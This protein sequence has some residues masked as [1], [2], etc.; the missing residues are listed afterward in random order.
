[1]VLLI[2]SIVLY[3]A[4]LDQETER[5]IIRESAKHEHPHLL[6]LSV[7]H[8]IFRDSKIR[9][10]W[11]RCFVLSP[12]ILR[13]LR[14][15]NFHLPEI[16]IIPTLIKIQLSVTSRLRLSGLFWLRLMIYWGTPEF[17]R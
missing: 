12:I 4:K 2:C 3:I 10:P 6:A 5:S 11:T 17:W 9:G 7:N 13:L 14:G 8:S 16:E 15:N 1:M